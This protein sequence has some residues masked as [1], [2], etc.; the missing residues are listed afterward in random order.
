ME[1]IPTPKELQL[2]SNMFREYFNCSGNKKWIF[3]DLDAFYLGERP[4]GYT[5]KNRG[6]F[7]C[8]CQD[9]DS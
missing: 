5:P 7:A 9:V 3:T 2:T 1:A 8:F 4:I 6:I